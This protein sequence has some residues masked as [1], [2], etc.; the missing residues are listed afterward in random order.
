MPL[1]PVHFQRKRRSGWR[2]IR[3]RQLIVPLEA[4]FCLCAVGLFGY[5][6]YHYALDSPSYRVRHIVVYGASAVTPAEVRE[7]AGVSTVDNLLLLDRQA[8]A[9]HVAELAYVASAEVQRE[10]PNTLIITLHERVPVATLMAG[11]HSFLID[12]EGIVL[13][14]T[15][16]AAPPQGPLITNVPDVGVVAVGEVLEQP[17]LA[18]ALKLWEA[19]AA[20]PIASEVTLS[21]ISAAKPMELTMYWDE[22]PYEVRWGRSDYATQAERLSILWQQ[23]GGQ[24]PCQEYL[25]LRFDEDLVCR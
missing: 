13:E 4:L 8:V 14:E 18:E 25:D 3:L 15:D 7:A 12:E 22:A 1:A 11:R 17:A 23:K 20:A 10:L 24:L 16:P 6:F 5:A 21:E 9:A 2:R 19:Y